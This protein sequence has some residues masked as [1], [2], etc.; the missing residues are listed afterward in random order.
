MLNSPIRRWLLTTLTF[1]LSPLGLALS[2]NQPNLAF[3][4]AY[5][6]CFDGKVE[7]GFYPDGHLLEEDEDLDF[8]DIAAKDN[9]IKIRTTSGE[10]TVY[11]RNVVFVTD[12]AGND[13]FE[14]FLHPTFGSGLEEVVSLFYDHETGF[15]SGFYSIP[16]VNEHEEVSFSEV[17]LLRETMNCYDYTFADFR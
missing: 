8:K 9:V 7:I 3:E 5:L 17:S 14:V 2:E 1:F 11:D 6:Q 15:L 13:T 4:D 12:G 10:V 16:K